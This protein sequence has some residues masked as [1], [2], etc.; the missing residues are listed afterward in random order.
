MFH[1]IK[2]R[3]IYYILSLAIIVLG[4]V[5]LTTRGLNLG[6]DFTGGNLVELRFNNPT[7]VEQVRTALDEYDLADSKIQSSGE[8]TFIIRTKA[9]SQQESDKAFNGISEKLGGATLLRNEL[10]GPVIGKELT[11]QALMA[12]AIASVLMVLYITWRFEFLQ[13]MAAIGALLH[14][15]LVMV[16]MASLLQVEIDSSFVAAVLTIIGYSIND[17]I[18]IFDRI[19][20]NLRQNRK[21]DLADLVNKS[22]WQTMARSINTV[23]T[24]VF[25]LLSLFWFGGST[26]HNFVTLLL[27][28]II[29]GAYSSIFNAGPVW[30]DLRR[31]NRERKRAAKAAA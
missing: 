5:S 1:I 28:G 9:M 10:V 21:E 23:L 2:N 12:L 29:S 22:L 24:V 16:G 15:V 3:K 8:N 30:Y 7:T 4:L 13:A 17:T 18:V 6:I 11:R 14:D 26:I 19:R 25:V 31:L 20:E 27:I